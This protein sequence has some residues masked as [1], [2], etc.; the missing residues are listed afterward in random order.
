MSVLALL[1]LAFPSNMQMGRSLTSRIRGVPLRE[2]V[3]AER[4]T[5]AKSATQAF[6]SV[7]FLLHQSGM[8]LDAVGRTLVRLLVTGRRLL[9]WVTDDRL[10][11]VEAAARQA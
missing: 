7:V 11:Q 9:E 1:V 6:L 5:L 4:D 2:H 10:T 8:M 3:L